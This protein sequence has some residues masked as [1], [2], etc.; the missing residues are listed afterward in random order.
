MKRVKKLR[1]A[2]HNRLLKKFRHREALVSALNNKNPNAVIGVMNE[3]VTRRKLLKCLGNLD[4]GEL[5]M[6]LGFLHKSVTLPKHARLLMALAKKVI[7]MRTK[8]IKASETLQRHAL[9]LRRMVREEVHI[10]RS[11]QE[12][13]GII[14]PLLKLARR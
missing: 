8:D 7:Q 9:N 4:V 1:V 12:I 5:G 14:L 13:Q 10:Q 3:L 11:L 2:E 6:L